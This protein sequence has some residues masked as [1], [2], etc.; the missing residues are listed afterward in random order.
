MKTYHQHR[1]N[2]VSYIIYKSTITNIL[3]IKAFEVIC[4]RCNVVWTCTWQ[5]SSSQKRQQ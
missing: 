5:T 3:K 1:I 4:D 2:Y